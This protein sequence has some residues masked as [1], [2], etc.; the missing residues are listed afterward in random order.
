V[1]VYLIRC[2]DSGMVKI[3]F[4]LNPEQRLRE[5]QTGHWET[6]S[7]IR[8]IEGDIG[9]ESWMHGRFSEFRVRGE[10]FRLTEEML[11]IE[12]KRPEPEPP[13][14]DLTGEFVAD[15]QAATA[16]YVGASATERREL[17][18]RFAE[19]IRTHSKPTAA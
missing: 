10:W 18:E 15:W 9:A 6:L 4:A 8:V 13:P 3:G 19:F 7:L 12:I 2:G 11:T 16:Y 5:L 1:A 14:D 17:I